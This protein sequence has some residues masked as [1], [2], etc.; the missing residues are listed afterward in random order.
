MSIYRYIVCIYKT[1]PQRQQTNIPNKLV[2]RLPEQ[3]ASIFCVAVISVSASPFRPPPPLPGPD[4]G[5]RSRCSLRAVMK[6][7]VPLMVLYLCALL[8]SSKGELWGRSLTM[9]MVSDGAAMIP[10][11]TLRVCDKR[12]LATAKRRRVQFD[13]GRIFESLTRSSLAHSLTHLDTHLG[14]VCLWVCVGCVWRRVDGGEVFAADGNS[15]AGKRGQ[16]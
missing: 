10:G 7:R 12:T 6:S 16:G 4:C 5:R 14:T 13:A 2:N 9:F 15:K 3:A 11:G 1:K 8:P